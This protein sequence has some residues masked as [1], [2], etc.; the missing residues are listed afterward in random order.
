[1]KALAWVAVGI[2]ALVL[3]IAAMMPNSAQFITQ[4]LVNLLT[5]ILGV[6]VAVFII[7]MLLKGKGE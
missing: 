4:F 1:M 7:A 5:T 2:V 3:I 6:I